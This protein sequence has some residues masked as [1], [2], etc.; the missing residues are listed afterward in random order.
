M[1]VEDGEIVSTEHFV[2][3]CQIAVFIYTH[4]ETRFL[5]NAN[6]TVCFIK[7]IA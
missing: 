6:T 5:I 7:K 4:P 3:N 1:T 2:H